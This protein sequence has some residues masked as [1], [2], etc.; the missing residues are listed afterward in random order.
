MYQFFDFT[1]VAAER[2]TIRLLAAIAF[3]MFVNL[4]P[5]AEAQSTHPSNAPL[6]EWDA[7]TGQ[8]LQW[9]NR[10][11]GETVRNNYRNYTHHTMYSTRGINFQG[12]SLGGGNIFVQWSAVESLD[13]TSTN[14][15]YIAY[16]GVRAGDNDIFYQY[17]TPVEGI[18]AW[19]LRYYIN[20]VARAYGNEKITSRDR[21]IGDSDI[22]YQ[23]RQAREYSSGIQYG[24]DNET[25]LYLVGGAILVGIFLLFG[26]L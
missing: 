25:I 1:S 4:A 9:L 23:Q 14:R 13:V 19:G 2:F 7:S 15:V 16:R 6:P 5:D 22:D 12:A 21:A 18:D 17:A 26:G 11:T 10:N 24:S 20:E 3:L 8:V